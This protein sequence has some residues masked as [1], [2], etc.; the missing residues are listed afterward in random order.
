MFQQFEE[1]V[2]R[3]VRAVQFTQEN[4]NQVYSYV[5][6]RQNNIYHTGNEKAPVLIIPIQL[7]G[8]YGHIDG[9]EVPCKLGDYII[10]LETPL[11][12]QNF[13]VSEKEYF[14]QHYQQ[15]IPKAETSYLKTLEATLN[16]QKNLLHLLTERKEFILERIQNFSQTIDVDKLELN[17][18]KIELIEIES[19][20]E[21]V[22][23]VVKEKYDY[24]IAFAEQFDKKKAEADTHYKEI[25]ARA[26]ASVKSKPKLEAL[27]NSVNW[28]M[29]D[30]NIE[31][32][33]DLY[34]R[35]KDL[36]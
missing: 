14:E 4:K 25:L 21:T 24:F 30:E 32:K 13:E 6:E 5:H 19:R 31:M 16:T 17:K 22:H 9:P 27:L 2:K 35:L 8:R 36:V 7:K 34:F 11:S 10:E 23:K 20:L 3:V 12:W 29:L 28:E 18:L 26:R 15:I 33:V 1:K